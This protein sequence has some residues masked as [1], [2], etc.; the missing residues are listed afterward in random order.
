MPINKRHS[1]NIV[2]LGL[3]RLLRTGQEMAFEL[4]YHSAGARFDFFAQRKSSVDVQGC[5]PRCKE[6]WER[7]FLLS[8][9]LQ[10]LAAFAS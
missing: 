4:E 7:A 1:R 6:A 5:H 2:V 3:Q 10:V 9:R 8:N